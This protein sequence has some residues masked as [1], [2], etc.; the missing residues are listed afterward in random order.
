[1]NTKIKEL[2]QHK[3]KLARRL[4]MNPELRATKTE[5][6]GM[7]IEGHPAVF[8]QMTNVGG[9]FQEIIKPGAFD[10]C[11]MTDVA[12]FVNHDDGQIPLARSRNNT[13]NSTMQLGIDTLGLNMRAML[14]EDNPQALQ[15]FSAVKREDMNGMSFSFWVAD[16][17]WTGLD[18]DLPT[19]SI[20]SIAKIQE[21]SAVNYP[22]YE[23]TDINARDKLALDNAKA[24]LENAKK[25]T[26]P[27]GKRAL[28]SG[29][30]D[31]YKLRLAILNLR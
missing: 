3:E 1:M 27:D 5:D 12:F 8:N 6:G 13:P 28:D 30:G 7:I 22:Q 25:S 9:W 31:I 20:L 16:E 2:M 11:D 18:T 19:R 24:V 15:L 23:G 21:V 29:L 17:E 26:L 10:G 14:G 4:F